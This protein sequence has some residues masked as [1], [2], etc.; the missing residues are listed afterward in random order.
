MRVSLF[1]LFLRGTSLMGP[2]L[3][4]IQ[5]I[6]LI[7]GFISDFLFYDDYVIP[8]HT[9]HAWMHTCARSC[10]PLGFCFTTR[11]GS[12]IW[13]PWILMSR[14]WSL[15]R[16]DSPSCWSEWRS[17]S[18]DLQQTVQNHILPGPLCTSRVF[19]FVKLVSALVLFI[20]VHLFVI[21]QLRMS[22]M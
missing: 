18:V 16:V 20:P 8:V 5:S 9:R 1:G 22:V 6:L 21:S 3:K 4:L 15:G 7:I 19:L 10:S 14:S 17:G 2:W 13:L 12:I 11:L